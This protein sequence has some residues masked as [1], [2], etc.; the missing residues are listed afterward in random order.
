[1]GTKNFPR[2][3]DIAISGGHLAGPHTHTKHAKHIQT[4]LHRNVLYHQ[5]ELLK[6]SCNNVVYL[7]CVSLTPAPAHDYFGGMSH[8]PLSI[9]YIP[10]PGE[11]G[12]PPAVAPL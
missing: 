11:L 8:R 12:A 5:T 1:M 9:E 2:I 10:C 3:L 4:E 6:V 7:K